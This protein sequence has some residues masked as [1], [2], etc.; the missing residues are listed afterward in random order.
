MDNRLTI[1]DLAGLLA[2]YTGK[3]EKSTERFLRE[4]IQVVTEGVYADKLVKVKGLGTFKIIPV[5]KR[6]SI[7]V[8]TGERFVI[9]AHYKFSFLPDKELREQVNRPFSIFETTELAA[10]VDFTDVPVVSENQ[11]ET[12]EE[13]ADES[14]EELLPETIQP[15]SH[16]SDSAEEKGLP[17]EVT[18][19]KSKKRSLWI[20]SG[21][22]LLVAGVILFVFC[23][24]PGL[25]GKGK[26][27]E[28]ALLSDTVRP[29]GLDSA[30]SSVQIMVADTVNPK[31]QTEQVGDSTTTQAE[32]VIAQVRIQPGSR[33]TL[34]ALKYYGHKLFWV[35]IYEYNKAVIKD[36]NNI[37]IG[38]V[39]DVPAPEMYGIDSHDRVSLEKAAIRQTEILKGGG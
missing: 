34:V 15:V 37:P 13:P 33:L 5:E 9:P 35:Y 22:A 23:L 26:S 25:S 39:I 2:K 14:V 16:E 27:V 36:P 4:F 38:T 10:D 7:H 32:Q 1:Q 21:V 29:E 3:D 6:E 19:K 18:K 20:G 28:L 31:P 17:E 24:R 8:N 12:S 11:S 30:S